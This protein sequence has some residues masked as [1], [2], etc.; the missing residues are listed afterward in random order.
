M[1]GIR[2]EFLIAVVAVGL[3]FILFPEIDL[4]VSNLFY[5]PGEGFYLSSLPWV[6][7]FY[8][9]GPQIVVILSMFVLLFFITAYIR[10][11]KTFNVDNVIWLYLVLVMLI[12]PGLIVNVILKDNWGRCRPAETVNFGGTEKF[13]PALIITGNGNDHAS[14][15]SGHSATGYALLALSLVLTRYRR[16]VF[17][18]AVFYGSLIGLARIIQGGHFLSDVVFSFIVV[19][20]TAKI[21]HF[22]LF[23]HKKT[24]VMLQKWKII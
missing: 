6:Q 2:K 14:F 22:F 19:Y 23:R 8:H 4:A 24:I 1:Y 7:F 16:L 13:S 5:T 20:L 21:L 12:G 15:V 10:R 9:Y 3:L 18:F 17:T 11:K